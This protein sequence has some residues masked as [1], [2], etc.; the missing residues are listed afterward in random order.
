MPEVSNFP[1]EDNRNICCGRVL[2][3]DNEKGHHC[4]PV[5]FNYYLSLTLRFR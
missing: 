2:G 3:E 5:Y 1:K 4:K